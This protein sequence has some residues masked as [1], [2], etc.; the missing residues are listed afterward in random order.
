MSADRLTPLADRLQAIVD[1]FGSPAS[2]VSITIED[3]E[4]RRI[5]AAGTDASPSA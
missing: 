1:P 2:G 3:L 4:G 5:A